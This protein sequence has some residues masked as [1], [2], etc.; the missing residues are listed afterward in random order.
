M[1][2]EQEVITA[3]PVDDRFSG[4]QLPL[5]SAPNAVAGQLGSVSI[6]AHGLATQ[7]VTEIM[8]AMTV[9]RDM[10]AIETEILRQCGDPIFAEQALF[11]KPVGGGVVE[12][13]SVFFA[14]ALY[15]IYGNMQYQTIEHS[16]GNGAT[17]IECI[18]WD[19][20]TNNTRMETIISLHQKIGGTQALTTQDEIR[21][22]DSR[23]KS[24]LERNTLMDCF[25]AGLT[26]RCLE[27]VIQTLDK[28]SSMAMA[29]P[30]TTLKKYADR[31]AIPVG[32]LCVF[33]NI[34]EPKYLKPTHCR[35]LHAI[36]KTIDLGEGKIDAAQLNKLFGGTRDSV[37]LDS[38][39]AEEA[40]EA[41]PVVKEKAAPKP[42]QL[43]AEDTATDTTPE[44][45][46]ATRDDQPQAPTAKLKSMNLPANF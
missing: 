40:P 25:N 6:Q 28:A 27:K 1:N 37:D 9:P 24:Y 3:T 41:P 43:I 7:K 18:V 44:V 34:K 35:R 31:F 39:A 20:Q 36:Y 5:L 32:K 8:A 13:L 19:K 46:S 30:A 26:K 15:N 16:K 23:Q 42:K 12:G 11:A 29:D 14:K 10:A 4:K 2:I 38:L 45:E 21:I 17:Q 22:E 33:L